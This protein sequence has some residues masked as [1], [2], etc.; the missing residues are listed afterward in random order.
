MD[1]R[2]ALPVSPFEPGPFRWRMGVRPVAPTEWLQV[3]DDRRSD[4]AEKVRLLDTRHAECVVTNPG[5]E[6][7]AA[8]LRDLVVA[9]LAA[10]HGLVAEPDP[11]LQPID[12]AG[13]LVQ[14]DLCLLE[15][16][17]A[18][19]RLTAASVCFPSWWDVRTK[20]GATLDT[21][22]DPVPRF[23]SD[24][25]AAPS[26]FLDRLR[27]ETV[28]GRSIWSLTA[29]S[30]RR[31]DG[32]PA[33]PPLD[34]G[35]LTVR[36]ERQTLRRLPVRG[37]VAF[38][39]RVH[40]WPLRRI[41]DDPALASDLTGA[42]DELPD[43]VATYKAETGRLRAAALGFLGPAPP[44]WIV[45]GNNVMGSRPDG[46]WNDRPRAQGRLAQQIAE[47]CRTHDDV[48]LLVFDGAPVRDV[49]L[50][51]GGNLTIEYAPRRGRDGAD[52]HIVERLDA[53]ADRGGTVVV[54]ADRGLRARLPD[55]TPVEGPRAFL[56]R[57]GRDPR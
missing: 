14:E 24:L 55:R 42:L 40:R 52:D 30:A 45:D 28:V 46:W 41:A 31:L 36:V 23:G 19:W 21:I 27:S 47:W 11:S 33:A 18:D 32:P 3:D 37:A 16:D 29:S 6:P 7:A 5:S 44:R 48:V 8:E 26:R 57:L 35:D 1:P 56:D 2:R 25:G 49:E 15:H 53:L 22:H 43:D 12:A 13:R 39:I 10:H 51:A 9:D 20:L 34:A 50:V 38:T 17:G 54:T 4:L